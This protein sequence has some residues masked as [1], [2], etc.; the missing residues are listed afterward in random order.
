V[1]GAIATGGRIDGGAFHLG[2]AP[3]LLG[4]MLLLLW[5]GPGRPSVDARIDRH[6]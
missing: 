5:L 4:V 1:F 6:P 2:V 3:T